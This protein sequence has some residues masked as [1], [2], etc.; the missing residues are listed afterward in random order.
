MKAKIKLKS[1]TLLAVMGI[2]KAVLADGGPL[3]AQFTPVENLPPEQRQVVT[4]VLSQ[5]K[6][7]DLLDWDNLAVGVN[8]NGDV[9]IIPKKDAAMCC[10]GS[11]SCTG[12]LSIKIQQ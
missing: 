11:P 7:L 2:S 9:V 12:P 10:V 1:V 3:A 6:E 8:E 4:D 5:H